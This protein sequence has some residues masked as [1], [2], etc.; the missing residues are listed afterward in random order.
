MENG[1]T[2]TYSRTIYEMSSNDISVSQAGFFTQ[3]L[4]N[5]SVK[6]TVKNLNFTGVI[7]RKNVG[8]DNVALGVVFARDG[9]YSPRELTFDNVSVTD[10]AIDQA[11][12][13]AAVIGY[14][15]NLTKN[16]MITFTSCR[17]MERWFYGWY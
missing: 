15:S 17:E 9:A 16:I 3:C 1:A 5:S 8:K 6:Y 13:G 4:A 2:I 10:S 11:D 12:Q 14:M 7:L